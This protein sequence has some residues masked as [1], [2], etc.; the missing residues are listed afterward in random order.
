MERGTSLVSQG[1][2][3]KTFSC[4]KCSRLASRAKNPVSARAK[5]SCELDIQAIM[6]AS[7][8]SAREELEKRHRETSVTLLTYELG[9]GAKVGGPDR[10]S[11][12]VSRT[13]RS[14]PRVRCLK[15]TKPPGVPL[16]LT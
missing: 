3:P 1:G 14:S 11:P 9:A 5:K 15:K 7:E 10:R 4:P 13:C 6:R 16:S 2:P 8:Q 12:S